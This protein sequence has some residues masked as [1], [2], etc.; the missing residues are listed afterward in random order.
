M[1]KNGIK[2]SHDTVPLR[3]PPGIRR[4]VLKINICQHIAHKANLVSEIPGLIL[5]SVTKRRG[6]GEKGM[7][8]TCSTKRQLIAEIST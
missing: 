1:R 3:Q 6:S 2:K 4:C 7:R 8:M 5:R